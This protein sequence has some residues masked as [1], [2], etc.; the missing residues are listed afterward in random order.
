MERSLQ[1]SVSDVDGEPVVSLTNNWQTVYLPVSG[2]DAI[3][4]M[5]H[6][7]VRTF[8]T[9]S[10]KSSTEWKLVSQ[11]SPRTWSVGLLD[12]GHIAISLDSGLPSQQVLQIS[13]GHAAEIGRALIDVAALPPKTL[14]RN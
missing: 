9:T 11:V 1:I 14:R 3:F 4:E 2:I 10:E 13:S 6:Q 12:D 7:R 8:F 5:I